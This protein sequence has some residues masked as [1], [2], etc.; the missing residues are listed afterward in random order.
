MSAIILNDAHTARYDKSIAALAKHRKLRREADT[1]LSEE[2]N[3][4]NEFATFLMP[5]N[6]KQGETLSLLINSEWL[7]FNKDSEDSYFITTRP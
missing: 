2:V 5:D 4:R 3:A 1:A 6:M 7:L